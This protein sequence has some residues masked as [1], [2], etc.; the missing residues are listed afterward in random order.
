MQVGL[1][2]RRRLGEVSRVKGKEQ[3][4]WARSSGGERRGCQESVSVASC[5]QRA[6]FGGQSA[7]QWRSTRAGGHTVASVDVCGTPLAGGWGPG[8]V[9]TSDRGGP[10]AGAEGG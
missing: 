7:A 4:R 10:A 8:G 3:W 1:V 2:A 6:G 5:P 9:W